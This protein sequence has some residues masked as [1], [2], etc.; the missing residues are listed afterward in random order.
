MGRI[1]QA[2]TQTIAPHHTDGG[3][4][5]RL[6]VNVIND[7]IQ[8]S[9]AIHIAKLRLVDNRNVTHT[10]AVIGEISSAIVPKNLVLDAITCN[11]EIEHHNIEVTVIIDVA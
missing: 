5:S 8:V 7:Q 3:R 4:S 6:C 1:G 10:S 11:M 2:V 9:V